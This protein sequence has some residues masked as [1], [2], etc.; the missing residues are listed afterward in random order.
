MSLK[1]LP[2]GQAYLLEEELCREITFAAYESGQIEHVAYDEFVEE[3]FDFSGE[4]PTLYVTAVEKRE[5]G[6]WI[7]LEGTK[8]T[9]VPYE[10]VRDTFWEQGY[11]KERAATV[12]AYFE[13]RLEDGI[14][15][16]ARGSVEVD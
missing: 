11:L 12:E 8:R 9:S 5:D 13:A 15:V 14:I 4:C 2:L 16:D 7:V 6:V 10:R 3:R 1:D